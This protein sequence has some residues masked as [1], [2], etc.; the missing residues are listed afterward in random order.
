VIFGSSR[1][2]GGSGGNTSVFAG[3]N[4]GAPIFTTPGVFVGTIPI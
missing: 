2:G 4:S 1:G 3:R